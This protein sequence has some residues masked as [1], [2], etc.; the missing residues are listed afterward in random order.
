M[1]YSLEEI[2]NAFNVDL[3]EARETLG[4]AL[5]WRWSRDHYVKAFETCRW[6]DTWGD[7]GEHNSYEGGVPACPYCV[8][9][10]PKEAYKL[11]QQVEEV[12]PDHRGLFPQ[13]VRRIMEE[14]LD[15]P[16]VKESSFPEQILVKEVIRVLRTSRKMTQHLLS[17][18][19]HWVWGVAREVLDG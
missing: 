10:I 8:G 7:A 4:K 15:M 5:S 14:T 18:G 1:Y 16:E 3:E 12:L 6:C 19:D 17:K 11:L 9:G 13:N 2:A